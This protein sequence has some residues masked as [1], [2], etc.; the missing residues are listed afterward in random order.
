VSLNTPRTLSIVVVEDDPDSRDAL[1]TLLK[2]DG[3]RVAAAADGPAALELA[4]TKDPDVALIDIGLPGLD[5]Y[6]VAHR[7]RRGAAAGRPILVA[8]TGR[9]QPE[10]ERRA[11]D[12]GFDAYLVK[13][14]DPTELARLIERLASRGTPGP[15]SRG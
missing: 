10:D 14:V 2:L 12:A 6:E 15:G 8:L 5:G 1:L 3:H 11:L 9:G 7:I 13:P 4:R